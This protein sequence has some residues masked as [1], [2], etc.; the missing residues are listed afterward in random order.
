MELTIS[1]AQFKPSFNVSDNLQKMVDLIIFS[2]NND[3]VVLPEGCLSGYSHNLDFLDENVAKDV[4]RAMLELQQISKEKNI[5]LIFGSCILE[6]GSWYNAGIYISPKGIKHMYKKVNLA[7]HERGIL[8]EG[9][10]LTCFDI[11]LRGNKIKSSIQLCREIRFPEQWKLLS[12]NGAEIIFYLTN[13]IGS[14]HLSVWNSHLV[15]RAAE[16]QRYI[17]SSNITDRE[18][19]CSSMVIS[20]NGKI[21]RQLSSNSETT[22]RIKIDLADNSD[23]Y[24][25]QGRTD[26]VDVVK[27]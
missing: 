11:E 10:E 18:Q 5:H 19:G 20:P 14:E 22:E 1:L 15:S 9:N 24:L 6:N 8:K 12:L 13:V 25:R 26:L 3:I 7:I 4:E 16:N 21:L 27:I 2:N 23:W 17:V